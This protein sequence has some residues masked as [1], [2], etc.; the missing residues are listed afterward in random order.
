[1]AGMGLFDVSG[2]AF[3]EPVFQL[4]SPLFD[5]ITVRLNPRYYDGRELVI[6]TVDNSPKNIYIQSASFNGEPLG[7]FWVER[8]VLM[9]GGEPVLEMGPEPLIDETSRNLPPSMSST[10]D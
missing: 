10:G 8:N 6:K 9:K 1:M 2:H 5:K 7:K 4:G 3:A